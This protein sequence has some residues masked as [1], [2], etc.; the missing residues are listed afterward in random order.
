MDEVEDEAHADGGSV[1]SD[2]KQREVKDGR[3][4]SRIEWR[5]KTPNSATPVTVTVTVINTSE[6]EPPELDAVIA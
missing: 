4:P 2:P 3:R 5:M 1:V 6:L